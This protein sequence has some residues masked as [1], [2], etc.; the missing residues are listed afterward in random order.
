MDNIRNNQEVTAALALTSDYDRIALVDLETGRIESDNSTNIFSPLVEGDFNIIGYAGQLNAYVDQ[1]VD[2]PDRNKVLRTMDLEIVEGSLYTGKPYYVNYKVV[3]DG[4]TRDYQ[5][6]FCTVPSADRKFI[7]VG[8]YDVSAPLAEYLSRLTSARRQAEAVNNAKNAFLTNLSHDIRTPLNG[9]MGLMEMAKRN[10]S[11]VDKVSKYLE[12]MTNESN[13]LKS[14]LNDVLD[15]SSLEDN[16]VSIIHQPL[17]INVFAE[18]C[19]SI[20]SNKMLGKEINLSTEFTNFIHPYVLGDELH[21][22]KVLVNVLDNAIKFTRDGD[23]VFFRIKEESSDEDSVTYLFE[24]EDTG[25]GMRP[26]FLDHIFDPFSQEYKSSATSQQGSG[27]GLTI[28]KKLIDLMDGQIQV[29]STQGVGSRFSIRMTFAIDKETESSLLGKKPSSADSLKDIKILLVEDDNINRTITQSILQAEGANTD[30]ATSGEEAMQM[31]MDAESGYY[32][33]I[34]MD[35]IMPGISGLEA[36]REIRKA[37]RS[38]STT[39]PIIATTGNAF[40]NDIRK[41][42]EAG[43]NAHLSKPVNAKVLT[44]TILKFASS[45]T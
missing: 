3:V 10:V 23:I 38:D 6:K 20:V 21:L 40:E 22:Q 42:K 16:H 1:L 17:N 45:H 33:I 34:L 19:V 26:E 25:I 30:T 5:T 8:T 13:H 18:S 11:D 37:G 12:S 28:S 43:M 44:E 4:K 15:I 29:K 14:L 36:T 7:A 39:I 27:L 32:D 35:I 41:S 2:S 31:Y 9:V 24:V